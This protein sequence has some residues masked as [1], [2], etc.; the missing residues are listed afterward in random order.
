MHIKIWEIQPKQSLRRKLLVFYVSLSDKKA[1]N[2]LGIPLIEFFFFK[3][4]RKTHLKNK[5]QDITNVRTKCKQTFKKKKHVTER[6][7][8][9]VALERWAASKMN[10]EEKKEGKT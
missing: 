4:K 9:K 3:Q 6:K 7:G 5:K 10:Q 8:M 1:S 2:E